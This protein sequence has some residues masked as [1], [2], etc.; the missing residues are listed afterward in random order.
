M[1]RRELVVATAG[2]V[3]GTAALAALGWPAVSYRHEDFA[4]FWVMGRM[5]LD[6]GDQYDFPTYLAAHQAIGSR[7]LTIVIPNTASFYPLTTALVFVPIALLPIPLSAPLW[8]VSQTVVGLWALIAFARRLIPAA[9]LRRDLPVIIALA[10]FSQPA[11][12]NA[13]GGNMG[14]LVIGIAA[15]SLALLLGGRYALAGAVAGLL[16][17]KPHPLLIAMPLVLLALPRPAAVRTASSAL[18]V[19]G[20]I[21]LVSIALRPGWIGELLAELDRISAYAVNTRQATLFGLLGP[22]LRWLSWLA[23][24]GTIV[25]FVV[26][27]RARPALPVVIGAAVCVSL[28]CVPYAFSYDQVLLAVPAAVAVACVAN[29]MPSARAAALAALAIAFV[30]LPWICYALAFQRG[31]ESLNARAPLAIL[32]A[33]ALAA[34]IRGRDGDVSTASLAR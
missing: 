1:S 31:D 29:A 10:A 26:W 24:A 23:V 14:G 4:S 2:T 19:G 21:T 27:L 34:R 33:L 32:V 30:L 11:W 15:S 16:V 8:L 7:A 22:D 17:I 12:R 20:A 9:L 5:L 25:A 6:G 3:V 18:A 28:F 13:E